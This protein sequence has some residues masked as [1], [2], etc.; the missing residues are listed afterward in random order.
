MYDIY[1]G[2]DN[3]IAE[4]ETDLLDARETH[5]FLQALAE[6]SEYEGILDDDSV[7]RVSEYK[8]KENIYSEYYVYMD[9]IL[10]AIF[11]FHK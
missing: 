7:F 9:E 2:N 6:F 1:D 5:N 4:N 8:T 3:L 10:I 11:K